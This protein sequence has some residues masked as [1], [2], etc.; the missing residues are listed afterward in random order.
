MISILKRVVLRFHPFFIFLLLLSPLEGLASFDYNEK[1]QTAYKEI[2]KLKIDKGQQI[3]QEE[4]AKD[5]NNGV[6]IYLDNYADALRVFISEDPLL[7]KT[8]QLKEADRI[9]KL[10]ALDPTHAWYRFCLAEVRLQ[11]AFVKLKFKDETGAVTDG[12][13]AYKLL[14]DNMTLHPTFVGNKKTMGLLNIL[15]GSVPANYQWIVNAIGMKG[16]VNEGLNQLK[17]V[18]QGTSI[19]NSEALLILVMVENFIL[20]NDHKD[21]T[22]ISYFYRHN[23]DNLMACF[24]YANILLRNSNAA[25]AQHI[26]KNRPAGADYISFPFLH[27]MLGEALMQQGDY[28][29]SRI[30]YHAYLKEY[31]GKNFIKDSYYKLMLSYLLNNE[32]TEAHTYIAKV[33]ANGQTTYDS[34]KYAQRWAES[35]IMPNKT[36]MKIRLYTDGGYYEKAEE[37]INSI[38]VGNFTERRDKLEYFYRTAR[39]YH[40]TGKLKQALEYYQTTIDRSVGSNF[41]FAPN[42]ALQMGYIYKAMNDKVKAKEYFTKAMSYKN[43]EYK[44]SI[45]N[46]AKAELAKLEE[47]E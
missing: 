32:D 47:D 34:D 22:S 36:L 21:Y 23:P 9:K 27:Y 14:S 2:N 35:G 13:S 28:V 15:I 19:F 41:Y 3:V 4:L 8:L 29:G 26:L 45:D 43:H 31:K 1:L 38:T 16:N 5:P 25:E 24:V 39:L 18:S 42:S 46:K 6:A 33:L 20:Q 10:S 11:W 37:L 7:Y 17:E 12:R 44:N 30:H 40:K